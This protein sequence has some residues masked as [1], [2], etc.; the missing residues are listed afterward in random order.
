MAFQSDAFQPD[1]SHLLT[2]MRQ[3]EDHFVERKTSN[4]L[5]DVLKTLVAFAN[6]T[7]PGHTSILFVGVRN[8]GDIETPRPN[9]ENLQ[10]SVI[11]E[12]DKIYPPIRCRPIVFADLGGKEAIAVVVEHSTNLPHFAGPSYVRLGNK[13]I[14]ASEP[15]FNELIARRNSKVSKI[16]EYKG[17]QISAMNSIMVGIHLRESHWGQQVTVIDCNQ[18][19]VTLHLSGN[20][21][22]QMSFEMDI[23]TIAH[24]DANN[25]LLLKFRR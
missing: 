3:V 5:R 15:Q 23:V 25:R 18:F 10:T 7:P 24:D 13:T 1:Y 19:V 2:R 6:S 16:L 8:N 21:P 11:K 4:D 17:K 9:L 20:P 12:I 22:T 14:V